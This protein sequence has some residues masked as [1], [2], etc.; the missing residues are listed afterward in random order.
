[1]DTVESLGTFVEIE[2]IDKNGIGKE[3][4]L[5]QCNFYMSQFKI[6]KEDLIS[7]SYSDLILRKRD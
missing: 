3:K 6:S 1:M 5:E 7:V 2:A 4:L